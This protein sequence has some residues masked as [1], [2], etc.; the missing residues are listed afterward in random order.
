MAKPTTRIPLWARLGTKVDPGTS[1][2]STGWQAVE[3]PPAHWFNWILH[4]IGEWLGYFEETT[5]ELIAQPRIAYAA[6]IT[7]GTVQDIEWEKGDTGVLTP[8]G[9]ANAWIDLANT[10]STTSSAVLATQRFG[11]DELVLK[12]QWGGTS[13]IVLQGYLSSTG[14]GVDLNV[15]DGGGL[16]PAVHLAI[17]T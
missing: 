16:S 17:I 15:I 7:L 14:A 3:R 5:D 8:S 4:T 13:R 10:Y 2:E 9:G 6:H 11:T 1:K 12:T